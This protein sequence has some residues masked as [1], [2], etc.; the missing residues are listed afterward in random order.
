MVT[1]DIKEK[2]QRENL[3]VEN[4]EEENLEDKS[5]E[6]EGVQESELPELS[7]FFTLNDQ[8]ADTTLLEQL[9]SEQ[10]LNVRVKYPAGWKFIDQNNNGKLDGVTFWATTGNYNPPPYI[11]LEVKE[12][13]LFSENR[14]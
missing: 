1:T 14:F 4:K 3:P 13:Y 5:S 7:N 10:T 11:H 2:M 8:N 12:K 6:P 9:Y